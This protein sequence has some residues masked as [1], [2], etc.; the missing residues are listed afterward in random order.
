MLRQGQAQLLRRLRGE[1]RAWEQLPA[2]ASST[3]H[4]TGGAAVA[5]AAA[6]AEPGPASQQHAGG[7][8]QLAFAALLGL[9][10]SA[11]VGRAEEAHPPPPDADKV[12]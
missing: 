12:R 9:A 5:A 2:A 10:G 6:A 7:S 11:A 3:L 8:W 4:H 1:V